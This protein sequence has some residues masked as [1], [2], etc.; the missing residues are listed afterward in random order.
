MTDCPNCA[1]YIRALR[2]EC[3]KS[4]LR[5]QEAEAKLAT[6]IEINAERDARPHVRL[7]IKGEASA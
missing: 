2:R 3:A 4:R 5:A 7:T 1:E 6:I